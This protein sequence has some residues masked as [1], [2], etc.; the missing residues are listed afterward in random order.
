MQNYRQHLKDSGEDILEKVFW[1]GA[2]TYKCQKCSKPTDPVCMVNVTP[3]GP[4]ITEGNTWVCD[5]C[6]TDWKRA[7]TKIDP[8]D[9][10]IVPQ[11][12]DVRFLEKVLCYEED[13]IATKKYAIKHVKQRYNDIRKKAEY[14]EEKL[15]IE[16]RYG[17]PASINKKAIKANNKEESV[18]Q[19]IPEN[20][21]IYIDGEQVAEG[22]PTLTF[23]A[24]NKGKYKIKVVNDFYLDL[25]EEVDA[26]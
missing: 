6:I 5:Q 4:T 24:L 1:T 17:N 13:Y 26:Y 16:Q 15:K 7:K 14:A 19:N 22:I 18:V 10:F 25:E 3:L 23:A 20:S 8:T 12:W 11:E 21:K 2:L 9:D